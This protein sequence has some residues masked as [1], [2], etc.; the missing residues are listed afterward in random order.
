M[1]EHIHD[2]SGIFETEES[3]R[4]V[5]VFAKDSLLGVCQGNSIQEKRVSKATPPAVR[6]VF[7][8]LVKKMV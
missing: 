8:L 7:A 1:G 4:V 5:E 2:V 6:L 3:V